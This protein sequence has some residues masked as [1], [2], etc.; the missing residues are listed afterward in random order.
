MR[1]LNVYLLLAG[2]MVFAACKPGFQPIDYGK[3]GC[4]HC[5]MTIID[6]KFAAEY[7]DEKGKA[8]KFDDIKCMKDYIVEQSLKDETLLLFVANYAQADSNFIDVS[9]AILLK[10]DQFKSPMG[11]NIAAFTHLDEAKKLS[12]QTNTETKDWRSIE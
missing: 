12:L 4:V 2:L 11:G 7:V 6:K 10:A 1:N 5:K 8:Y 9:K 3:D